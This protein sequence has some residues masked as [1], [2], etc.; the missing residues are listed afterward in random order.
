MGAKGK[1]SIS[2]GAKIAKESQHYYPEAWHGIYEGSKG[3]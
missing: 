2:T 3:G 1:T